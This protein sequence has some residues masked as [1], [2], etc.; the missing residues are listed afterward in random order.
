MNSD[1]GARFLGREHVTNKRREVFFVFLLFI[2][3]TAAAFS[4]IFG[5][6][7]TLWEDIPFTVYPGSEPLRGN[8]G[9]FLLAAV[10][11][12]GFI[13]EET[14]TVS[15]VIVGIFCMTSTLFW[16]RKAW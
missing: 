3:I 14:G 4:Q 10:I 11:R 1:F 9:L 7:L 13:V 2:I 5:L 12:V 15:L 6:F 8:V 16:L